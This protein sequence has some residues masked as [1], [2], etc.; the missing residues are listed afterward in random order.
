MRALTVKA[1]LTRAR[2]LAESEDLPVA[3]LEVAEE[4]AARARAAILRVMVKDPVPVYRALVLRSPA[5]V[6]FDKLGVYW[7]WSLSHA[8]P[9]WGNYGKKSI[10][11]VLRGRV[12]AK[13]VDW[14][15][16]A[17]LY[18]LRHDA[19]REVRVKKG[20]PVIITG[21]SVG[22]A[23]YGEKRAFSSMKEQGRA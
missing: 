8:A 12:A 23:S 13:D 21:L 15:S 16:S 20:A 6:K 22:P 3:A 17:A 18:A 1:I 10:E 7:T 4:H 19:E 5:E 9:L 2:H 11:I 14:L